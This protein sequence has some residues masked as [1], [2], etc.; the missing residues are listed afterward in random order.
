M[1]Q[2]RLQ[3]LI[4]EAGICSRRKAE[5]LVA[6]N[7]VMI[8]GK[9]AKIGDKADPEIDEILIDKNPLLARSDYKVFLINKPK[10][11]ISTCN[12]PYGRKTVLSLLPKKFRKGLHPVGRL[13]FES[14]GAIILTNNGVLT[15]HLT[16]PRYFHAKTYQ[17]LVEGIPSE[18]T[19]IKWRNGIMLDEKRTM[20]ASVQSLESVHKKTLLKIIL[21]EGRYRQIRRVAESLGHPVI[22]LQRTAICHL[23]LNDLKEGN[24]RKIPKS[25]WT[26]LTK[27]KEL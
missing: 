11:V 14:R 15:L 16:H 2:I 26:P 6:K 12:D 1:S 25:A 8:N 21:R 19:L 5:I 4:A 20:K 18:K 22:D 24:W 23:E 3:K 9:T 10:G 17:V 7:R 27:S 13:D